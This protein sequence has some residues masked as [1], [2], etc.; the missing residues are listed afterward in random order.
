MQEHQVTVNGVTYKL[1]DPFF[2][3][4][5]ANPIDVEGTFVLSTAQTDRF[6]LKINVGY[7]ELKE[8]LEIVDRFSEQVPEDIKLRKVFSKEELTKLQYLVRQVPVA[9]DIKKYAVE[10]V[11]ST[12]NEKK[13]IEYGASPRASLALIMAAKARALM[14]GR[15]YVSKEDI[16]FVAFPVLRHR[17]IL[18]FEAERQNLSE[19]DVITQLI[20]KS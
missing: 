15:K 9:N 7:P 18:N 8:E 17:I 16:K 6:L 2:V 3:L 1:D 10:L 14:N 19:D 13:L 12:R 11:V 4:A 5:T 20:K